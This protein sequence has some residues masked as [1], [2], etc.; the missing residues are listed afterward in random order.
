MNKFSR[1]AGSSSVLLDLEEWDKPSLLFR[2]RQLVHLENFLPELW[3]A[4]FSTSVCNTFYM[5]E[6]TVHRWRKFVEKGNEK[7]HSSQF[8]NPP[9]EFARRAVMMNWY[10]SHRL[11]RASIRKY[12]LGLSSCFVRHK[13]CLYNNHTTCVSLGSLIIISQLLINYSYEHA[14]RRTWILCIIVQPKWTVLLCVSISSNPVWY[15]DFEGHVE[16]MQTLANVY[17]PSS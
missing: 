9:L 5:D 7:Y 1:V 3:T 6:R 17:W 14:G 16:F 11:T 8:H 13:L 10:N 15:P 4:H 12:L 2:L